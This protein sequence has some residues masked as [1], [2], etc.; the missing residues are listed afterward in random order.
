MSRTVL[1]TGAA[2][3]AG[4]AMC[5]CLSS[6][7][8]ELKVIAVDM[9]QNTDCPCDRFCLAECADAEKIK[10]IIEETKP[11]FIIHLAGTFGSGDVQSIYR[12]NVLS[13]TALLEAMRLIVP[14]SVF[15]SAGSAA[16]YGKIKA[17]NLPVTEDN[18][19]S[20]VMPYG[21]SK[22]LATQIAQYYH[23]VHS[24]CTMVVR[25]FQ[26]IG[27][28]VTDRLAPGAFAR[29][30]LDAKRAGLSEI[31]VGNLDS[32]RDFMDIQDAVRAIWML[33]EK[34]AP[35]EIFNLC[36]GWPVKMGELLALM[37]TVLGTDIRPVVENAYL[38]GNADVD[39]VYGSYEKIKKH[40]GWTPQTPLEQSVKDLLS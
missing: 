17:D 8:Q 28:G 13:M 11:D 29:R 27:K 3:F 26:L 33:C 1:I 20:P 22:Y 38:R 12:T 2:G 19:C 36:S 18:L 23:R 24:L 25:P 34:P 14:S 35:G 37:Q 39:M 21:L 9:L 4:R 40:C 5:C 10:G 16:E 31:Q 15:V 7:G 30:L 6:I 32:S